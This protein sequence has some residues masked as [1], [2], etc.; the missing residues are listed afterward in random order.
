MLF[1]LPPGAQISEAWD[2]E[3]R[4]AWL[5]F[6]KGERGQEALGALPP[7]LEP[8]AVSATPA[9]AGPSVPA[10]PAPTPAAPWLLRPRPGVHSHVALGLNFTLPLNSCGSTY[11]SL[12]PS[13]TNG[14]Y[15]SLST[16]SR[17]TE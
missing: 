16:R 13:N 17:A 8:K 2:E 9:R 5:L 12:I 11:L 4:M 15:D 1:C 14:S 7:S 6:H 3:Q 10:H